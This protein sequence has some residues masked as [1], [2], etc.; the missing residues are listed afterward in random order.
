MPCKAA[1]AA[2][3]ALAALVSAQAAPRSRSSVAAFK[4]QAPCPATGQARG[5]C[6]GWIVDHVTPLCAGG[7][8]DPANMQWQTTAEA[9]EKDRQEWRQCRDLRRPALP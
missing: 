2:V 9:K 7:P 4:A 8:D 1:A 6:P 3:V 5:V